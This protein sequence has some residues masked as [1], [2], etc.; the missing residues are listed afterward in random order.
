MLRSPRRL[1]GVLALA[2][3]TACGGDSTVIPPVALD[4]E[5]ALE[6][7]N[8]IG[9][10]FLKQETA[11]E[12]VEV[13]SGLLTLRANRTYSGNVVEQW[14]GGSSVQLFPET[15]AG[16]YSVSGSRLTF[17]ENGGA[18]YYGTLNGNRLTATMMDV[19]FVFVEK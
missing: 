17:R 19:T 9:L 12:R 6:T 5:Y 4:G 10:P 11:S 16:T 18:T 1:V 14:T 7:V 15:S 3:L 13:V 8:G 2:G